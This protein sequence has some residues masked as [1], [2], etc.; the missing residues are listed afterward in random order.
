MIY[1]VT[2]SD[3]TTVGK[4]A[5]TRHRNYAYQSDHDFVRKDWQRAVETMAENYPVTYNRNLIRG[6]ILPLHV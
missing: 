5:R 2:Y 4:V 6:M 3:T 1:H